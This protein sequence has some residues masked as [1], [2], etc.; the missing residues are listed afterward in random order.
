MLNGSDSRLIEDTKGKLKNKS[1]QSQFFPDMPAHR[2]YMYPQICCNPFHRVQTQLNEVWKRES[3]KY[4]HNNQN[5]SNYD[6]EEK[7]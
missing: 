3:V 7:R 5:H 2:M 4:L 6:G 1:S